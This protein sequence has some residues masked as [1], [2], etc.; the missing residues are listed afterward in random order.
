MAGT[1]PAWSLGYASDG[2]A[3]TTSHTALE[4]RSIRFTK[5][6]PW[7]R[8]TSVRCWGSTRLE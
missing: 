5:G 3:R 8:N 4:S 6:Q 7:T 1:G 2:N